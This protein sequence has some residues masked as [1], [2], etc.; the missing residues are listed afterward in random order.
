LREK[1][2]RGKLW[3]KICDMLCN[4]KQDVWEI[5]IPQIELF[6]FFLLSFLPLL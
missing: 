3:S 5:I 4:K 6:W 1:N 2:P